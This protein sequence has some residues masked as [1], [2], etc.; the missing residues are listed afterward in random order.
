[1]QE[2]SISYSAA[3]VTIKFGVEFGAFR[4]DTGTSQSRTHDSICSLDMIQYSAL[5]AVLVA[6]CCLWL[7]PL[8]S[9]VSLCRHNNMRMQYV[10]AVTWGTHRQT[11]NA[12]AR[13]LKTDFKQ[14]SA[15]TS[16]CK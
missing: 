16:L 8:L 14:C 11:T 12:N 9:T 15:R 6:A 4:F 10:A 13:S 7:S 2:N 3:M 5:E 1:M